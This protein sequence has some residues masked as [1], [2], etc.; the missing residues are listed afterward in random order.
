VRHPDSGGVGQLGIALAAAG[1][2][3]DG[4]VR[5]GCWERKRELGS[6]TSIDAA[7]SELGNSTYT[8]SQ[9]GP[10]SAVRKLG[11]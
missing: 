1:L 3:L 10:Q 4:W 8:T 11:P 6:R 5:W 7:F 9:L 2:P